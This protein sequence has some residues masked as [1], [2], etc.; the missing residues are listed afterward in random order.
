MDVPSHMAMHA[1]PPN[2]TDD[3]YLLRKIQIRVFAEQPNRHAV[4]R[5][6]RL[7]FIVK[8]PQVNRLTPAT[9]PGFPFPASG[10]PPNPLE[11]RCPAT[12]SGVSHVLGLSAHAEIA[13]PIVVLVAVDVIDDQAVGRIHDE[14]VH[15]NILAADRAHGVPRMSYR[16]T[17]RV[18]VEPFEIRRIDHSRRPMP[19]TDIPNG[20]AFRRF[21]WRTLP[22]P[23]EPPTV[24]DD[25][26]A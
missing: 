3:A 7:D 12:L 14:P 20:I 18:L 21:P 4:V 9:D 16:D 25:P 26:S 11:P 17:P 23:A 24:H 6:G 2:Q 10:V 15:G 22:L 8:T 1:N 5:L 19:Q 13:P